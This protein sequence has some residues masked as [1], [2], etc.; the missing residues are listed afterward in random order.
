MRIPSVALSV[1]LG[2]GLLLR[3]G[4]AFA[5]QGGGED[6]PASGIAQLFGQGGGIH[7]VVTGSQGESFLIRTDNGES[8]KVFYGPNTRVMKDRQPIDAGEIHIGDTVVAAGQIDKSAKTFGA[9]FL[10]DVDAAE[11]RKAREGFGKTWTAGRVTAIN[12]LKITIQRAGDNQKQVIAVDENTSFRK[13]REDVT[14]GDIKVGDLISA[15][16]ALTNNLFLATVLRVMDPRAGA[17]G[18]LFGPP[19]KSAP[20]ENP[21]REPN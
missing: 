13:E 11:V 1:L 3:G 5:A 16:G 20:G 17:Q 18:L 14:L 4:C 21:H 15:R 19:S 9:V 6:D 2:L 8:Y 12:D 7:G 10:Y